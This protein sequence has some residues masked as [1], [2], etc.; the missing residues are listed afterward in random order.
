[1]SEYRISAELRKDSGKG[2]ARK[3]RQSGRIPGI[4]YQHGTDPIALSVEALEFNRLRNSPHS[5]ILIKLGKDD[6]LAVLKDVD[7]DP[8]TDKPLHVDFM[9]VTKGEEFKAVVPI[10]FEGEPKGVKLGGVFE[11]LV[12]E[13]EISVLPMKL[14]EAITVNVTELTIGDSIVVKDVD[15]TD[16]T[17]LNEEDTTLAQV[18]A[19]RTVNLESDTEEED[20]LAVDDSAQAPAEEEVTEE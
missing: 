20:I 15:Q 5:L 1:M 7:L 17:I 13:V 18:I 9:G 16:F 6:K 10:H 2:I 19:E 12:Y 11:Q 3:V 8:I 4:F 14:P